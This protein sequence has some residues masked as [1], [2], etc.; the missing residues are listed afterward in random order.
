MNLKNKHF[1][2]IELLPVPGVA[3]RATVSGEATRRRKHSMTFTLIE[4]L[5]VI[6]IIA[7]LASLLLPAL[8]TARMQAKAVVCKSNLKQNGLALIAFAMD[9]NEC[10]PSPCATH[11]SS[12]GYPVL[13][14]RSWG[15][16][17]IMSGYLPE[18]MIKRKIGGWNVAEFQDSANVLMC[19]SLPTPSDLQ[20]SDSAWGGAYIGPNSNVTY[21]MR[22]YYRDFGGEKWFS[23]DGIKDNYTKTNTVARHMPLLADSAYNGGP[24]VGELGIITPPGNTIQRMTFLTKAWDNAPLIHRRHFNTANLWFPDGHCKAMNKKKMLDLD[25]VKQLESFESMFPN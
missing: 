12:S 17:L 5:V 11:P 21:G 14:G 7:I 1:T 16:N 20:F 9:N 18:S 2:L 23:M 15:F 10:Y 19:P 22:N 25:D 13:N 3:R 8:S 24:A 4:L 6:A